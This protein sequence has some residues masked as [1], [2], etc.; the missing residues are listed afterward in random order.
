MRVS[1]MQMFRMGSQSIVEL[2]SQNQRTQEQ[3]STGKKLIRPSDDPVAATRVLQVN[4]DINASKQYQDNIG[5]ARNRLGIADGVLDGITDVLQR[6]RDLTLSA[7]N[8]STTYQDRLYYARE[9]ETRVEE[10]AS[11]L[12]TK[13]TSNNYLFSGYNTT[14]LPFVTAADGGYIYQGDQSEREVNIA[15]GTDISISV[16]GYSLF[17]SIE[18]GLPNVSIKTGDGRADASDKLRVDIVDEEKYAELEG[19]NL[20]LRFNS[21]LELD[22]A[23]EN[24][25]VINARTGEVIASNVPVTDGSSFE[26]AGMTMFV[27]RT[28]DA[29]ESIMVETTQQD[30]LLNIVSSIF[31]SLRLEE[32]NSSEAFQLGIER[33]IAQ[34]DAGI[35]SVLDARTSIGTR[36]GVLDT[37]ES[38]HQ[39]SELAN[40]KILSELQD[41]D[42]AEAVSQLSFETFV[43][44][45]A[46]SSFAQISRLSLFDLI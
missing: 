39:Q 15:A 46:Q 26:V 21:P 31:Q 22:P 18:T 29:G 14:Q 1:T 23:E 43:L 8:G 6:V 3:I 9:I 34:V 13:D 5:A 27:R 41:L 37:A 10:L 42:Y 11:L 32:D 20:Q 45:A 35:E 7:N 25:S 2:N 30:N 38:I 40:K 44:E 17:A 12:N 28:L 33:A 16:D 24:L 36:L 19:D 4:S